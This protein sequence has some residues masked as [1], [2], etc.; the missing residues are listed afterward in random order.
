MIFF[1]LF[2]LQTEKEEGKIY[3]I[4]YFLADNEN[5][6]HLMEKNKF[7]DRDTNTKNVL[8]VNVEFGILCAGLR[9]THAYSWI[10]WRSSIWL[11]SVYML[12]HSILAWYSPA[13]EARKKR[14]CDFY[15]YRSWIDFS[16][17]RKGKKYALIFVSVFFRIVN[18]P[19]GPKCEF[20]HAKPNGHHFF[21]WPVVVCWIALCNNDAFL[22]YSNTIHFISD[23]L[24]FV[25]KHF[26]TIS[27]TTAME[28][29]INARTHTWIHTRKS[30]RNRKL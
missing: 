21:S 29:H 9:P 24:L 15:A 28:T 11:L 10:N 30:K 4:L 25:A 3:Y 26:C 13:G 20:G 14:L 6:L 19:N 8:R 23:P 27:C 16:K 22:L 12:I 18:R 17:R 2:K 7:Q 5:L 1:P